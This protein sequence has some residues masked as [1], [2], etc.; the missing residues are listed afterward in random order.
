MSQTSCLMKRDLDKITQTNKINHLLKH[1]LTGKKMFLKGMDPPCEVGI[2][3]WQDD[4][5]V[6]FVNSPV[7]TLA[8][9]D[10]IELFRILGRYIELHCEVLNRLEAP[11]AY[12]LIVKHA[13]IAKKERKAMRIPVKDNEVYINNIRT[14][15][16]TIDATLFSVPTSVKVG[17]STYEN[18]LKS[19]YDY[20]RIDV[21]GK[22][23][24]VFDQIRKKGKVLLV[25]DTQN[26][27]T[28][29][30]PHPDCLNYA[31]YL[32]DN[33]RNKI[34]EYKQNRV[35]SELIIPVNYIT[36]DESVIALG[37]IQLQSRETPFTLQDVEE[38]RRQAAEMVNR[39]RDSNTVLVQEKQPILNLSRGGIKAMITHHELQDYLLR[40]KGMTFDLFFKGQAPITLYGSIRSSHQ[41]E[42]GTLT[43]GLF[44]SGNSF[45][46]GEMK[47]FID[48]VQ[49]KERQLKELLEKRRRMMGK[50]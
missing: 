5:A 11:G 1:H 23:G 13:G 48:N 50:K 2:T 15:K 37:Y 46:E 27:E 21:F 49:H 33:L 3:G 39:I 19:R 36:H 30:S 22:R 44:I 18:A 40:Q 8:D 10:S 43:L 6:V 45:R 32:E 42:D 9:G 35:K 16:N 41:A 38:L 14:S 20:A 25:S 29:K 17:F 26:P 47:R 28:Y 12:K 24:T 4:S 7:A 31:D 34:M